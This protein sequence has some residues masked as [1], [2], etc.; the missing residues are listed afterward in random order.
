MNN[1]PVGSTAVALRPGVTVLSSREKWM[2]TCPKQSPVEVSGCPLCVYIYEVPC[3]CGPHSHHT[4][5]LPSIVNCNQ[6]TSSNILLKYPFNIPI[7]HAFHS[8]SEVHVDRHDELLSTL[9]RSNLSLPRKF[10]ALGDEQ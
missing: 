1:D 2:L 4:S 5:V 9:L 8:K 10:E 7:L 6:S 3:S